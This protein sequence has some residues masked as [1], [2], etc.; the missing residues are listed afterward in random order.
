MGLV[1]QVEHGHFAV[2]LVEAGEQLIDGQYQR[3]EQLD[4]AHILLVFVQHREYPVLHLLVLV[5]VLL[6]GLDHGQ[7]QSGR[8]IGLLAEIGSLL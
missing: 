2:E 5:H 7:E 6:E 3:H 1:L 4:I 8:L